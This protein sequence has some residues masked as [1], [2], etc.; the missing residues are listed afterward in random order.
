MA[1]GFDLAL[2]VS[3]N[4]SEDFHGIRGDPS[5][6]HLLND[7][8]SRNEGRGGKGWI[9]FASAMQKQARIQTGQV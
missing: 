6:A 4:S 7:G 3:Y 1:H 8:P 9:S 2:A 5:W